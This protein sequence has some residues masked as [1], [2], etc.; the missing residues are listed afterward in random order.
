MPFDEKNGKEKD[1]VHYRKNNRRCLML[2]LTTLFNNQIV[3]NNPSPIPSKSAIQDQLEDDTN[4]K[5]AALYKGMDADVIKFKVAALTKRY[6]LARNNPKKLI[7][8]QHWS[9]TAKAMGAKF[10]EI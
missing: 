6:R 3:S 4:A 9:R 5:L 8:W 1:P 2:G 7:S 10:L